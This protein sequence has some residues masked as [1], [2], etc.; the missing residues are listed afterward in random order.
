M[1]IRNVYEKVEYDE[2]EKTLI[3]EFKSKITDQ[4][5]NNWKISDYLKM[6]IS[7]NF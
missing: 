5:P 6:L 4:L 1:I 3:E 2:Y 7:A